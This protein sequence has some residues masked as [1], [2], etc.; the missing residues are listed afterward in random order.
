MKTTIAFFLMFVQ[1][2]AHGD[3][4]PGG[5][6]LIMRS[7]I[8]DTGEIITDVQSVKTPTSTPS[9]TPS[10]TPSTSPSLT[11]S[12]TP[13]STP[14]STPSTTPSKTPSVST[15]T[16]TPSVEPTVYAEEAETSSLMSNENYILMT[17]GAV[18]GIFVLGYLAGKA[19]RGKQAMPEDITIL[20]NDGVRDLSI[21]RNTIVRGELFTDYHDG[22]SHEV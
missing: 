5:V 11:P 13:S 19:R 7:I 2:V 21:N 18:G 16:T 15:P 20:S 10:V 4:S 14:S 17:I 9:A 22:M 12:A 3:S 6:D 8:E 1:K